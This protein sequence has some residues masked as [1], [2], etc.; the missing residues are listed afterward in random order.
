MDIERSNIWFPDDGLYS[1]LEGTFGEL[2]Q[3]FENHEIVS[4]VQ[5]RVDVD[6]NWILENGHD[7]G[8]PE[9]MRRMMAWVGSARN[10]EQCVD[11]IWATAKMDERTVDSVAR[12]LAQASQ[13]IFASM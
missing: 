9:K 2:V 3:D 1:P 6:G 11:S 4:L 7:G 10:I 5:S 13:V 12:E 8:K